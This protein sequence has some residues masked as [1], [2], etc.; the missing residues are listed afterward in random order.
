MCIIRRLCKSAKKQNNTIL[1][2]SAK[3]GNFIEICKLLAVIDCIYP[4]KSTRNRRRHT[5]A[6]LLLRQITPCKTENSPC[7]RHGEFSVL[8][9]LP[10]PAAWTI[11]VATFRVQSPL[12][13]KTRCLVDLL[14]RCLKEKLI[15]RCLSKKEKAV[16]FIPFAAAFVPHFACSLHKYHSFSFFLLFSLELW[17]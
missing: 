3:Y 10:T 9:R 7:R 17:W 5:V 4:Y 2:F 8:L 6:R 1:F 11:Y 15:V 14:S 12:S 13:I 16:A